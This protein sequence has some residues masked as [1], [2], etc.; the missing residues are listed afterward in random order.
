[1]AFAY[2]SNRTNDADRLIATLNVAGDAR[3]F[4]EAC[5]TI[6][7]DTNRFNALYDAY[8]RLLYEYQIAIDA[9]FCDY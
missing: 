7:Y 8:Q 3:L 9:I 2:L 5:K 4:L 1:M 6:D